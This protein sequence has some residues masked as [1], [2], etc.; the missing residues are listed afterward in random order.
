MTK[1]RLDFNSE[2]LLLLTD[3]GHLAQA[4]MHPQEKCPRFYRVKIRGN[5]DKEKLN[6][7][8]SGITVNGVKYGSIEARIIGEKVDNSNEWIEGLLLKILLL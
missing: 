2:G 4:A 8:K 7:L 1:G 3:S 5:A 6:S